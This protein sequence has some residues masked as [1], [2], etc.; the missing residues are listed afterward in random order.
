MFNN[1]G[2]VLNGIKFPYILESYSI[3]RLDVVK[4]SEV[5]YCLI[6][7]FNNSLLNISN[8]EL[9]VKLSIFSLTYVKIGE[10]RIFS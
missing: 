7:V 5:T 9:Y 8:L 1:Y 6:K 2:K 3:I 4:F 10:S